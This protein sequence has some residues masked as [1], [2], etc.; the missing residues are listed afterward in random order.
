[1]TLSAI[2]RLQRLNRPKILVQ[3]AHHGVT[4][5][6]RKPH[7]LHLFGWQ[8]P[9]SLSALLDTLFEKEAELNKMRRLNDAAYQ[10]QDHIAI[11]TA[12][13]AEATQET[14]QFHHMAA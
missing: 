3:A 6:E 10:I 9:K 8:K 4:T 13:I 5:Y 11:L 1:M 14:A 2:N 12:L 7:L